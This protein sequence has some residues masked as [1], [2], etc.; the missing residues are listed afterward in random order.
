MYFECFWHYLVGGKS[1]RLHHLAS[2]FLKNVLHSNCMIVSCELDLN[3]LD[4]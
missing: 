1:S 3:I 2:D 4:E